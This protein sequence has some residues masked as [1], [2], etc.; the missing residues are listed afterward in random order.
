M[1]HTLLS[2]CLLTLSLAYLDVPLHVSRDGSEVAYTI[3]MHIDN[4]DY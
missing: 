1:N 2:L 3:P 4:I